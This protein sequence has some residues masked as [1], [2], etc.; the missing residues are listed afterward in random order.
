MRP[1][2]RH[3]PEVSLSHAAFGDLRRLAIRRPERP[4]AR[5]RAI[6]IGPMARRASAS[7]TGWATRPSSAAASASSISPTRK[8]T[9]R[10]PGFSVTIA[11]HQH[12]HRRPF[13]SACVN[14][15]VSGNACANGAPTGPYSIVDPFPTGLAQPT[16]PAAG[17][18]AN[19]GNSTNSD[20]LHYKIPR[21]YQYSLGVQRQLPGAIVLDVSF[22]GNYNIYTDYGQ[23]YGNPQD[24]AG[25]ALQQQAINDPT[26]ISRQVP[27]PVRRRRAQQFRAGVERYGRG[28]SRST[29]TIRCGIPA[30]T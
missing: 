21:T 16:G 13:P 11:L 6:P 30:K 2:Q 24:A 9:T 29:I 8:T 12:L 18:L 4:T 26:I 20:M 15:L 25:I 22:A 10:R 5:G 1:L 17:A 27:N 7:P 3:Q 28:R 23:N 19:L 14:P